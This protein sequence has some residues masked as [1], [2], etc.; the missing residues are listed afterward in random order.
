MGV[1]RHFYR[2]KRNRQT[3]LRRNPFNVPFTLATTV[4]RCIT[5]GHPSARVDQTP[6]IGCTPWKKI[7]EERQEYLTLR[8]RMAAGAGG[9]HIRQ[10]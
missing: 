7:G 3:F 1:L 8:A 4:L 5:V 10:C 6:R 9:L 2:S